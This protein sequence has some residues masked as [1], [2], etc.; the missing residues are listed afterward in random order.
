MP[1]HWHFVLQP[2]PEDGGEANFLALGLTAGRITMRYHAH[3]HTAGPRDMLPRPIQEFSVQ[4]EPFST[5]LC[6]YSRTQRTACQKLAR[7]RRGMA[8]E[9]SL[10]SVGFSRVNFATT[11]AHGVGPFRPTGFAVSTKSS[12]TRSSIAVRLVDSGVGS[13]FG[14]R[15]NWVGVDRPFGWTSGITTSGHADARKRAHIRRSTKKRSSGVRDG[16][17]AAAPR[18][19]PY[20][21]ALPSYGLSV[22]QTMHRMCVAT[23]S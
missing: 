9:G 17:L 10:Y 12:T 15:K 13:P 8:L 19:N 7:G 18:N 23:C 3:Y 6:R 4:D 16:L 5:F 21:K 20:L 11:V 22:R 2:G 1:T 14:Q